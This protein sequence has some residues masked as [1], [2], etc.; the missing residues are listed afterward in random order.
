M[1]GLKV[2][3]SDSCWEKNISPES[4]NLHFDKNKR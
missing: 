4:D 1:C 3:A 2:A